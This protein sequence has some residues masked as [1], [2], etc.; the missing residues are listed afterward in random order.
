MV[1]VEAMIA[2]MVAARA[3]IA[4]MVSARAKIADIEVAA[5]DTRSGV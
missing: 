3:E 4:V 1:T 5:F 2:V